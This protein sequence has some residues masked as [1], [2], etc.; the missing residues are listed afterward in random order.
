MPYREIRET[1]NTHKGITNVWGDIDFYIRDRKH[2]SEKPVELANRYINIFSNKN[3]LVYIPFAG[4][5][6]EIESCILNDRNYIASEISDEYVN[7]IIKPRIKE[8]SV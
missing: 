1:Y 3:D 5:G 6:S 2:P 7:E 4:S 8:A